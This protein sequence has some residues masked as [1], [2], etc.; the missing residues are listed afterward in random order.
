[1][2]TSEKAPP[3]AKSKGARRW[4][5]TIE[6]DEKWLE[7]H[8]RKNPAEDGPAGFMDFKKE[9]IIALRDAAGL[10]WGGADLGKDNGD[11]MHFDGGTMSTAQKLRNKTRDVRAQRAAQA[12]TEAAQ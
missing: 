2:G 4:L 3:A 12:S 8:L 9:L 7:K 1:M 10:R 11:L 5:K 6:D